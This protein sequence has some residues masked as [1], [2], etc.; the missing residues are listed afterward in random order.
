MLVVEN[1]GGYNVASWGRCIVESRIL[2]PW[3]SRSI[4]LAFVIGRSQELQS[5]YGVLND[6]IPCQRSE[7]FI[8]GG[9]LKESGFCMLE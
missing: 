5:R 8:R 6:A 7:G 2:D 3:I 9:H 1:E 4:L